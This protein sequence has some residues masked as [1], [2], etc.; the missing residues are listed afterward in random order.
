MYGE[1]GGRRAAGAPV[2]KLAPK[3]LALEIE[4]TGPRITMDLRA[5]EEPGMM[6][7]LAM[8]RPFST[9]LIMVGEESRL[10]EASMRDRGQPSKV[11]EALSGGRWTVAEGV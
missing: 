4:D 2:V 11:E 6:I 5:S 10:R 3:K 1:G 9:T 8:V 7:S